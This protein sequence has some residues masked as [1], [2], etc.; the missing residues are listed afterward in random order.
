MFTLRYGTSTRHLLGESVA[1]A[2]RLRLNSVTSVQKL[3][4]VTSAWRLRDVC[5]THDN[6]A[7]T[8]SFAAAKFNKISFAGPCDL[9]YETILEFVIV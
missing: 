6:D 1:T 4:N 3:R 5:E 7:M 9:L 2:G 8:E